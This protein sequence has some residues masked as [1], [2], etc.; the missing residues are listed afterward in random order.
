MENMLQQIKDLQQQVKALT[1][2]LI[3]TQQELDKA[4]SVVKWMLEHKDEGEAD[5]D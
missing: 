4:N 5:H 3:L 2:A 1:N